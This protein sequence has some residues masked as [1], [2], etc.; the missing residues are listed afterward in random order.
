MSDP[1]SS[2]SVPVSKPE[3]PSAD[4]PLFPH[5]SGRWAKKIDGK[6]H[7]FG[8]WNDP[9]GALNR[10]R[11]FLSGRPK[12]KPAAPIPDPTAPIRPAGSPIFWHASGRWA[13][14]IRGHL[15]YFGRGSHDTALEEYN[16]VK[17]DLHAGR[18]RKD[19]EPDGMTIYRLC[20]RFLTAKK[21]QRDNGELSAR[22]FEEYG[23][24]CKRLLK[25]FGRS[26]A[27]ADLGPDDFAKLRK[28]M[29]RTWGPLKLKTEI[30][31]HRTPFLWAVKRGL[32]DRAPI[33][34]EA[35]KVPS[36]WVIR[37]NRAAAGLKMFEADE[38]RAMLLAA[39]QPIKAMILLGVN[40]GFGN[41]DVARLPIH[42]TDLEGGWIRFARPKTG[43]DR[44]IPLWPETI[45]AIRDW[46]T[47]R[48]EPADPGHA[49]L[50]FITYK[51]GSW[52]DNGV[53]RA[54]SH[55]FGKLLD[56]I[57]SNGR[58]GFYCLR[59]TFQTQGDESGDFIAVR[60]IMGHVT[61]DIA[62]VY[63]ERVSD[64]R[65]R[66]VTEHV[67]VW[68]FGSAAGASDVPTVLPF[69]AG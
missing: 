55:E 38:I 56:S 37:R 32:I 68:L 35:F 22:A 23:Y 8:K 63:R 31:R 4:F 1:N 62:D 45:D 34:A 5:A 59:H 26:R 12:E 13:K 9:D 41:G 20:T 65:L 67:R 3:K 25:V 39:R 7:Y 47:V 30:I 28:I 27:V 60:K 21:D 43:V 10:Y 54:L 52:L 48:P 53:N 6:L 61:A 49:D 15:H 69:K 18:L 11:D 16:R 50:L 14:K 36:A 17:D 42:A 66:K 2:P 44:K 46:L 24:A 58:R 19:R 33:M 51:R 64:Q 57:G 29:S 40:C